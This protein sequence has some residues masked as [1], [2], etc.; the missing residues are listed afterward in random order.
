MKRNIA[1]FLDRDGVINEEVGYL[2]NLDKLKIIP[3]AYEAIKLIN[4]SGMKAVVI[5]NQAGVAKGLF[6]EDF[7]RETNYHLQKILREQEA[8]IN[9]FYYCPHHPTEGE[10]PYRRICDCRKPA[11]G[12]LVQAARDLNIDLT[13]SYLVGDRFNDMEAATKAGVKGILVKT[14]YA[15]ELLQDDGPDKAKPENKPDF[16]AAD[17]LDAVRWILDQ[18]AFKY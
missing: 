17:I 7:V 13:K 1:V 18:V 8:Y 6:T 16:I 2:D 14:G 10:E 4:K 3:G 11:P 9:N 5:T 12:M 15:S